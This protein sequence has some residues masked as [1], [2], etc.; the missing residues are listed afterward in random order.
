MAPTARLRAA[1][2][3]LARTL[4]HP[5]AR[6][7]GCPAGSPQPSER[8]ARRELENARRHAHR[9]DHAERGRGRGGVRRAEVHVVDDVEGPA[10]QLELEALREVER[11]VQ[12]EIGLEEAG[13]GED[14]PS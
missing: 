8:E 13:A 9:G 2:T 11:A 1:S 5:M 10:A 7:N 6:F 12:R 4:A 3:F 14:I